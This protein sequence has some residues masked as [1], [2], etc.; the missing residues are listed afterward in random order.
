MLLCVAPILL[1]GLCAV[2]AG[3]GGVEVALGAEAGPWEGSVPG[4]Q[5]QLREEKRGKSS[6]FFGLMGKRVGGMSSVQ[7]VRAGA[8][9][10]QLGK[11]SRA[12][13]SR[14]PQTTAVNG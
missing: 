7:L 9:S 8:E 11:V 13:P 10:M 14:S 2:A 3:D 5:L 1:M 6:Q 4:I 12:P